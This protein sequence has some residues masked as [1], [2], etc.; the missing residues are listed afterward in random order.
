MTKYY[1]V[2]V[3]GDVEPSIEGPFVTSVERDASAKKIRAADDDDLKNGL[4]W[5]N[6]DEDGQPEIGA[7]SGR[8]F[9]DET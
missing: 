6:I 9:E 1:L 5:L 7:Y 3:W 8:F 2:P 4:Y